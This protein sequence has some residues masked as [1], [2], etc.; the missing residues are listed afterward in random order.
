M[1][2]WVLLVLPS[3]RRSKLSTIQTIDVNRI[4]PNSAIN[5]RRQGVEENV[6]KVKASIRQHGYWPDQPI[7]IRPHPDSESEYDYQN[8]T[9][10]CRLKA[11]LALGLTEIPA[12][13][14]E[15][16]DDQAIQRSWLENEVRG[17]LTYSDRAYWV[18]RIYKRYNGEGYTSEEAL[19]LAAKYLGVTVQTV[20]RYYTLSALPADLKQMV[21]QGILPSRVAV[22]I[23]RNTYDGARFK[24]SQEAMKERASWV[25]GLDRD[26]R[27][28]AIKAMERWGH[29]ASIADLNANVAK[30]R[31]DSSR[32]VEYAI[33]SE[34][35][36]DLLQWGLDRGL[37]DE[38]VIIGHMV[39][40]VLKR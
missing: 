12:F 40:E 30:R 19:G 13:I 38:Q 23:V 33:P 9:G 29:S 14:L 3:E 2:R 15:L 32:I 11:C 39:A 17:D 8:V 26:M 24:R 7:I 5:V 4:D 37:E 28:H 20:M 16:S 18:E 36:D 6:E 31:R 1:V 10:Q 35:Y 27:E 22:P 21:D 25:L 34:L